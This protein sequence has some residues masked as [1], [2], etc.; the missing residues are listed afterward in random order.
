[1]LDTQ[2]RIAKIS[3]VQGNYVIV[4]PRLK[5]TMGGENWRGDKS[6][7]YRLYTPTRKRW[8]GITQHFAEEWISS[9]T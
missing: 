3:T 6:T 1:M 9:V 4:T 5:Q 2:Y 7:L 8:R